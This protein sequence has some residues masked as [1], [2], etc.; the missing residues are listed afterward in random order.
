M[1]L[2]TSLT[3]CTAPA[4]APATGSLQ[5]PPPK[6]GCS[7]QTTLELVTRKGNKAT[8]MTVRCEAGSHRT[9]MHIKRVPLEEQRNN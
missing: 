4:P 7:V 5:P 2:S 1:R 8:V 3:P 9:R 6:R